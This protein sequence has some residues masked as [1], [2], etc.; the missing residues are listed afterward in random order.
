[1]T[2]ALVWKGTISNET[3]PSFVR[4]A[5][6]YLIR[7]QN[8]CKENGDLARQFSLILKSDANVHFIDSYA[9]YTDAMFISHQ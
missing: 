6:S 3:Y 1:M 9:R 4:K 5:L 7:E 8:E 2:Y